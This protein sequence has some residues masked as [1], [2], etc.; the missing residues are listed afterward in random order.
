[1]P[2]RPGSVHSLNSP[3][4]LVYLD[5]MHEHPVP[6]A[7]HP[8]LADFHRYYEAPT[9]SNYQSTSPLQQSPMQ[10]AQ[11]SMPAMAGTVRPKRKQVKNAC[12]ACQRACKR[13]DV[14]RPCERCIK[15]GM[16]DSCRD[17]Q[18]KERKKGVKRGPYK[19]RDGECAVPG[20]HTE[21]D[22]PPGM[23]NELQ[24]IASP[25]RSSRVP[26]GEL[27]Q[28]PPMLMDTVQAIPLQLQAVPSVRPSEGNFP[29]STAV[30]VPAHSPQSLAHSSPSHATFHHN[31]SEDQFY[32][33]RYDHLTHAPARSQ[34]HF[35]D[36]SSRHVQVQ[37]RSPMRLQYPSP[38]NSPG[39]DRQYSAMYAD[40]S[41]RHTMM[42]GVH[43]DVSYQ[44]QSDVGHEHETTRAVDYSYSQHQHQHQHQ[45][46][47]Q[48]HQHQR[49]YSA[50]GHMSEVHHQEQQQQQQQYY[51]GYN[52]YQSSSYGSSHSYGY[53][54]H[55]PQ[56]HMSEN[57]PNGYHQMN[58]MAPDHYAST[59]S[60]ITSYP[61]QHQMNGVLQ[62]QYSAVR[63]PAKMMHRDSYSAN[64]VP[65]HYQ[66]QHVG[67]V[68]IQSN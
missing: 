13:C 33:P 56:Q 6:A 9:S 16:A 1:M 38:D 26:S 50:D 41:S 21:A 65:H 35:Q 58:R 3:P 20:P 30:M 18:R 29:Y 10:Q 45:Q 43:H 57:D 52:S 25:K 11:Q 61:A 34:D 48:Q 22:F 37:E 66:Q 51:S 39:R 42:Q 19:K 67:N 12:M 44:S 47:Q 8:S 32:Q 4:A 36:Y 60:S 14:G 49:S 63:T 24:R 55:V 54:Q 53:S 64:T 23:L 27:L 7:Q 62:P 31:S 46:H 28:S 17:S 59:G 5:T 15:Y 2:S 68:Q 40:N